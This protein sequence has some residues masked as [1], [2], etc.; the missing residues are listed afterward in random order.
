MPHYELRS[1]FGGFMGKFF[2]ANDYISNSHVPFED[3][4]AIK[5]DL[6]LSESP[7]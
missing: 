7:D 2:N 4:Y 6:H 3:F 1:S 5:K